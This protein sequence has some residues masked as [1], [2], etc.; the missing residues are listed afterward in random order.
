MVSKA[1]F[2]FLRGRG[3]GSHSMGRHPLLP[4]PVVIPGN[5]SDDA[6][7]YLEQEV[8]QALKLLKDLENEV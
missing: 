3:K 6:P 2:E 5:D 1:G 4:D 8:K 7:Q